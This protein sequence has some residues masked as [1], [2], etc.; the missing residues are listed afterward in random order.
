MKLITL[1]SDQTVAPLGKVSVQK[2]EGGIE[3]SFTILME[4]QGREA[5]GWR[6]G[7]ALDA[8]ASMRGW[9]G[10]ALEGKVPP[11]VVKDYTDRG[12]VH[13][14]EQ[15]GRKARS[16][17]REAYDDAIKQGF[18]KFSDNVVEPL[19]RNFIAY[20]AGSFDSQGATSLIYW[21]CGDGR[22]VEEVGS[23]SAEQCALLQVKGPAAAPF[24]TG[25]HL[26]PALRCFVEKF[27]DAKRSM[28]LFVT[29]GKLDDLNDVVNYTTALARAIEGGSRSPLKCVLVG[30]GS[31][32]DETQMEVLDNLDTGTTIDIWDHK[33]ASE[34]RGLVEI[35]AEVVSENHIVA[36]TASVLDDKQQIVR[37][38]TDGLPARV[39]VVLP[40]AAQSFTVDV[41][42]RQIT[43]NI[44]RFLAM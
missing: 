37:K 18:L 13:M 12:W 22:M 15:D 14:L 40:A 41:A 34:M 26:L 23:F 43:Q 39:T 29:D 19:A 7:V 36:P 35:F 32:I 4:P 16:F 8:S 27:A 38:F 31:G 6:T 20:L 25:T 3:V 9:Y 5:E 1:P 11:D 10:R 28:F 24:G 21:A 33:I 42:G 17:E 2:V 44:G 30:V